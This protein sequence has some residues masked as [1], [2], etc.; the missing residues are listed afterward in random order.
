M[1]VRRW[2]GHFLITSLNYFSFLYTHIAYYY[3]QVMHICLL[4]L[5][6][7]LKPYSCITKAKVYLLEVL[8]WPVDDH[9]I[10]QRVALLRQPG[11]VHD[12]ERAVGARAG[13]VP[14]LARF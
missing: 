12:E 8:P 11:E 6:A 2:S 9:G 4:V 3:P 13:R 1:R 10:L 14:R 7:P 5:K